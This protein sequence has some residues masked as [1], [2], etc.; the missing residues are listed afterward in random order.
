MVNN[1]INLDPELQVS[2]Q[3]MQ[4]A[5]LNILTAQKIAEA[6]KLKSKDV[7][8][9]FHIIGHMYDIE[10][11]LRRLK[12]KREIQARMEDDVDA[13]EAGGCCGSDC[14]CTNEKVR[15]IND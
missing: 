1:K 12:E 13:L 9:V 5:L 4:Q 6:A 14:A 7:T 11:D 8:V 3:A 15:I 10:A 2:E